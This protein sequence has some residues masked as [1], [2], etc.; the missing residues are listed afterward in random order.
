M[1]VPVECFVRLIRT[2]KLTIC[3]LKCWFLVLPWDYGVHGI[4]PF[5]LYAV[6]IRVADTTIQYLYCHVIVSI[7]PVKSENMV[8]YH[9]E[10]KYVNT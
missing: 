4:F 6:Q 5:V 3:L 7:A 2:T 1:P 10:F 9:I 8:S